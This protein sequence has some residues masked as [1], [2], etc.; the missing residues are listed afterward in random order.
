MS[1]I[2]EQNRRAWNREV[3]AGNEWTQPV[4]SE[5]IERARRG[6][7]S[8]LLTPTQA[9]PRE[10]FGDLRGKA[11]LGLASGGGQQCP[12]FAAAG[13]DVTSFDA[14]DAQLANDR[15]VAERD[16]LPLRTVQ[17][18]MADLSVFADESFDLVFNPCS[19]CFVED[20]E[21][22]WR[23]VVR[24]LRPGGVLLAGFVNPWFY[25][26]DIPRFDRGELAITKRL[27]VVEEHD[28]MVECSHTLDA[29]LG[30]QMRAGLAVTGFYE[31][32]WD[33]WEALYGVA[34]STFAT[35]AIKLR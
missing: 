8:V 2:Y 25:L 15:L 5:V 27:P 11:V 34:P 12:I 32:E 17:G 13:A 9:V 3:E 4:D 18:D 10:W 30:G 14:S 31:D 35:R 7:W 24:V 29:L 22:V 1:R 26:F 6:D 23:E 16:G 33:A 28:G 19:T 20:V 21:P